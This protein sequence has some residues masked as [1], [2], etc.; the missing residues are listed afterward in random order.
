MPEGVDQP[1]RYPLTLASDG[2][3]EAVEPLGELAKQ[4]Q[5]ALGLPQ[6]D[7]IPLALTLPPGTRVEMIPWPDGRVQLRSP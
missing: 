4:Y 3:V 6:V 1:L 5:A 2:R 7:D